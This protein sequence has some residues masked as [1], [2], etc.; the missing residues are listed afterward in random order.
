MSEET[1]CPICNGKKEMNK[2]SFD[3][4]KH[5]DVPCEACKGTGILNELTLKEYND[6]LRNKAPRRRDGDRSKIQDTTHR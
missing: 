5:I 2:F 1:S 3:L 6:K 4:W